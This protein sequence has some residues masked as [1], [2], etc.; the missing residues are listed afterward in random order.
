MPVV[1]LNHRLQT[2][3]KSKRNISHVI[4]LQS[5][6]V[7]MGRL[8]PGMIYPVMGEILCTSSPPLTAVSVCRG[9]FITE[10]PEIHRRLD[11]HLR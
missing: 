1:L 10:Y 4:F 3:L 11:S 6:S 9:L 8:N 2:W 7:G 5:L